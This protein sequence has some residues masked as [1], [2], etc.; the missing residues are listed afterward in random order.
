[1]FRSSYVFVLATSTEKLYSTLT[2]RR[3]TSDIHAMQGNACM[4]GVKGLQ[5]PVTFLNNLI[6]LIK[7][8]LNEKRA[9]MAIEKLV[10][11][12]CLFILSHCKL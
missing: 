1:M 12:E 8:E 10:Q 9:V 7:R 11:I 4:G 6:S 5:A 2:L 3:K